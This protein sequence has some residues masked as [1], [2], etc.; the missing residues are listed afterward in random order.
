MF[1]TNAGRIAAWAASSLALLSIFMGYEIG[2]NQT[3]SILADAFRI[4]SAQKA[5]AQSKLSLSQ[6]YTVLFCGL[7]LGILTEISRSVAHL[8]D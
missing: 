7:V 8:R 3:D 5:A 1:F 6:G 2:W 4:D